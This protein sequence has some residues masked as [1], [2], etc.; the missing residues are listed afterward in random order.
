ME[1]KSDVYQRRHQK[2]IQLVSEMDVHALEDLN[3][4]TAISLIAEGDSVLDGAPCKIRKTI[5]LFDGN[6][7][8]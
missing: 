1:V 3:G 6:T 8:L 4:I 7:Y 2:I 5:Q